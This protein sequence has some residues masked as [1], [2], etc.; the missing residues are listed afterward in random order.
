MTIVN[1]RNVAYGTDRGLLSRIKDFGTMR[2]WLS[3]NVS[4]Y[5]FIHE[6]PNDKYFPVAVDITKGE[7]ALAFML[8]FDNVFPFN[9]R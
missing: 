7:D 5:R 4:E 9:K 2:N 6:G 1:I 8:Q 3:V